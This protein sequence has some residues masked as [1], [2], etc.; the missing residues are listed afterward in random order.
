MHHSLAILV[1]AAAS[2]TAAQGSTRDSEVSWGK[3]GVSLTQYR[4]DAGV[5][6]AQA[7]SLDISETPAARQMVKASRALDNIYSNAWMYYPP[8]AGGI[9]FG[10]PWREAQRI[11]ESPAVVDSFEQIR[12]TQIAKLRLCLSERGYRQFRLTED[13]RENLR[14]LSIGSEK[15]RLFLHGL[16]S[17]A[18]VL[19]RQG[20]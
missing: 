6:A 2:A 10:S 15:R 1:L 16:G 20:L 4:L 18:A 19:A 17:N 13:Q 8:A 11:V 7:I 3:P 12:A 14:K 5:C 9:Q